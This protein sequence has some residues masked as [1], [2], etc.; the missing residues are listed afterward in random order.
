MKSA[1]INADTFLNVY[2]RLDDENLH[3]PLITENNVLSVN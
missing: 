1:P 3:T 2:S